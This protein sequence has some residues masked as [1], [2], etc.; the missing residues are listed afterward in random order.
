M[1]ELKQ[2]LKNDLFKDLNNKSNELEIYCKIV[3]LQ[4]KEKKI[5]IEEYKTHIIVRVMFIYF[6]CCFLLFFCCLFFLMICVSLQYLR[7]GF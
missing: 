5:T 3:I 1:D 4:Y 2:I 7:I 6:C